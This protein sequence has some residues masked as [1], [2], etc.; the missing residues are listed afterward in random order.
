MHAIGVSEEVMLL[1]FEKNPE[2][3]TSKQERPPKKQQK[4]T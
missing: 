2:E 4:E 3:Q 1:E